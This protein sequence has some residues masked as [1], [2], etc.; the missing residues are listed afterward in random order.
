MPQGSILGP[1]LFIIYVNGIGNNLSS[2]PDSS[3]M[4]VPSSGMF[5]HSKTMPRSLQKDVNQL[6][7]WTQKWQLALNISKCKAMIISNKRKNAT[8]PHNYCIN[9]RILDWVDTYKYLGVVIHKKL[10]WSD[11]ILEASAKANRVLNLLRRTMY[12]T[13]KASKQQTYIALVRPHLE[14]CSS[15]WNP[16]QKKYINE[17]VKVQKR[18][19]RWVC[20]VRWD[21]SINN[22]TEAY[23]TP[24]HKLGW[25]S[26]QNRRTYSDCCQTFKIINGLDCIKFRDYFTENNGNRRSNSHSLFISQSRINAFRYSFFVN[27]THVWNKLPI[28]VVQSPSLNSFKSRLLG[29]YLENNALI[30]SCT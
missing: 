19:A 15:V 14:Y 24:C 4:T 9:N 1:L 11:H 23:S 21:R 10:S 17:L 8:P 5:P 6:F 7:G 22:W 28:S 2:Q 27:A 25:L 26:L 18:A 12:G 13:S 16:H 20:G 29:H 3:R 30:G